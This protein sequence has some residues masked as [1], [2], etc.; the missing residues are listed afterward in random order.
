MVF[1]KKIGATRVYFETDC[2]NLIHLWT[3]RDEQRSSIALI[4]REI[5]DLCSSLVNFSLCYA[6]RV[7]NT[8]AHVLAKQV[9]SECMMAEWHQASSCVQGCLRADCNNQHL[10]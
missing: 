1:A 8:A 4:L 5:H 3:M 10:E 7:C 9:S 6:N 2:Q